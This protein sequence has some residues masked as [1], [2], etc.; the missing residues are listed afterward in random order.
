M[1][2]TDEVHHLGNEITVER[3]GEE[4]RLVVGG[5]SRVIKDFDALV[6]TLAFVN[7]NAKAAAY[8][9]EPYGATP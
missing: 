4:L 1:K 7:D 9:P 3:R 5:S 2:P 6:R 8:N